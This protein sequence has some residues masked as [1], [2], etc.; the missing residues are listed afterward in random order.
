MDFAGLFKVWCAK[1]GVPPTAGA[2]ALGYSRDC[3]SKWAR[4]VSHPPRNKIPELA[5]K[6]NVRPLAL[7]EAIE[8][9]RKAIA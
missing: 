1:E 7:T 5:R 4:G 8:R 3:G 2:I 6:M 9:S